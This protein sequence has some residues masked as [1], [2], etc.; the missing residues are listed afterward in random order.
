MGGRGSASPFVRV[1]P[2]RVEPFQKNALANA[3]P[4]TMG[5]ALGEKGSPIGLVKAYSEANP[6]WSRSYR[7]Y[8]QNCQRCVV[9]Y[10]LRRR[11]YDVVAQPTY[12]G[13]R[14]P[15]V[16]WQRGFTGEIYS[17]WQGAFLHSK[18]IDVSA[19]PVSSGSRAVNEVIGNIN[20]KLR[21]WGPGSR[22]I[23]RVRWK[24]GGGHVF[25]VENHGGTP[26]WVDAQLGQRVNM[27]EYISDAQTW[28]VGMVRTDNLRLSS[29]V[30][31]M[32]MPTSTAI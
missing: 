2:D 26:V 29:R 12:E 24:N 17:R 5:E 9:A 25:N 10:E 8:S 28:S 4:E 3:I 1:N 11:G 31:N 14:M 32:V 21:D 23:V 19:S 30:R 22:G 6:H 7:E 20:G 15:L 27:R 13:D 18:S 16:A